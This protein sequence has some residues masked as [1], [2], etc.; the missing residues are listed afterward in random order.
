MVTDLDDD[1]NQQFNSTGGITPYYPSNDGDSFETYYAT[2]KSFGNITDSLVRISPLT[3]P[4]NQTKR[5]VSL[6]YKQ[7]IQHTTNILP[8]NTSIH[9]ITN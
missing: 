1:A 5:I 2:G 9:A 3:I 4:T 8:P 7:T 6:M